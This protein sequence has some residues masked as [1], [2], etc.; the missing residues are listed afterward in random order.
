MEDFVVIS[1]I[2][3]DW[4]FE[5]EVVSYA[6]DTLGK[7]LIGSGSDGISRDLEFEM[8]SLEDARFFSEKMRTT[9]PRITRADF[10]TEDDIHEIFLDESFKEG[11]KAAGIDL[12]NP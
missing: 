2:G 1:F 7:E 3:I 5:E 10:F 9:F 12:D 11:Y 8:S 6:K 4:D